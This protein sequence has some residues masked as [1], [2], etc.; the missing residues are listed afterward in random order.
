MHSKRFIELRISDTV[1]HI[2]RCKNRK[3][4]KTCGSYRT[5]RANLPTLFWKLHL[6]LNYSLLLIK[7]EQLCTYIHRAQ[8]QVFVAIKY[9]CVLVIIKRSCKIF[10]CIEIQIFHNLYTFYH[11]LGCLQSKKTILRVFHVGVASC[12]AKT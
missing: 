5:S 12:N 2:S 11:V 3:G 8:L 1:S 6:L 4:I 9:W 7:W 10:M